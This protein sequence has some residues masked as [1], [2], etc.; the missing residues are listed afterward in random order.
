MKLYNQLQNSGSKKN[1]LTLKSS[2]H[3]TNPSVIPS[4]TSTSFN[5]LS[6]DID[7]KNAVMDRRKSSNINI[8]VNS[9]DGMGGRRDTSNAS[10]LQS[11]KPSSKTRKTQGG[12]T[13]TTLLK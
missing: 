5:R 6:K 12:N 13:G 7:K 8:M 1:E 11:G 4:K 3:P 2:E 9:R 10:K